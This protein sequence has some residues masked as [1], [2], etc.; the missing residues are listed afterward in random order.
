[1]RGDFNVMYVNFSRDS[2]SAAFA[3]AQPRAHSS[4]GVRARLQLRQSRGENRQSARSGSNGE[5]GKG[6]SCSA[7]APSALRRSGIAFFRK[8]RRACNI[9]KHACLFR[10]ACFYII[11]RRILSFSGKGQG[12]TT[13]YKEGFSLENFSQENYKAVFKFLAGEREGAPRFKE[14]PP[15][16]NTPSGKNYK[17]TCAFLGKVG[18]GAETLIDGFH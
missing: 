14:A 17:C 4:F 1:M 2:K 18:F 12:K 9:T 15:R 16:K 6:C 5:G 3:G 11:W 10:Q 13:L 7:P 8:P